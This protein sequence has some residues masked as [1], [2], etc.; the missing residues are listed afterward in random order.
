MREINICQHIIYF[1]N[2]EI[3]NHPCSWNDWPTGEERVTL[4]HPL[5]FIGWGYQ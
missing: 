3:K 1:M 5:A 2:V 4:A